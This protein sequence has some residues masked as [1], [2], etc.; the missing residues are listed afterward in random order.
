[1]AKEPGEH[2]YKLKQEKDLW[3]VYDYKEALY[4]TNSEADAQ[5]FLDELADTLPKDAW[6]LVA[7]DKNNVREIRAYQR[8]MFEPFA[9]DRHKMYLKKQV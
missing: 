4:K 8:N 3:V 2:D 1:M 9:V 5:A 7:I 6:D